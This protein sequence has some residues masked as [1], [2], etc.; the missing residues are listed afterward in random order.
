MGLAGAMEELRAQREQARTLMIG[1]V[2]ERQ[3]GPRRAI[4]VGAHVQRPPGRIGEERDSLRRAAGAEEVMGDALRRRV[5][6]GEER[7]GVGVG[8]PQSLLGQPG[9]EL[10]AH[11]RVSE[12]VAAACALEHATRLGL[13]ER[14]SDTIGACECDQRRLG[15]AII[16]HGESS[17]QPLAEQLEPFEPLPHDLAE[18]GRDR[19]LAGSV[20]RCR[21]LFGE[22]RVARRRACDGI[23]CF[24]RQRPAGRALRDCCQRAAVE[25]TE[26]QLHRGPAPEE[27]RSHER[28]RL[29]KWLIA[30]RGDYQ[31]PLAA[32]VAGEMMHERQRCFVSVVQVIDRQHHTALRGGLSQQ[33]SDGAEHQTTVHLLLRHPLRATHRRQQS[34]E[35]DL[36]AVAERAD[37]LRAA[38]GERVERFR[39]RRVGRSALRLVPCTAQCV[40][41]QLL[42]LGEH[43]L[44]QAR[45]ADPD[46]TGDQQRAPVRGR[47]TLQRDERRG[48][49]SLPS[50]DGGAKEPGRVNRRAP[51]EL[52][53]KRQ[54]LLR[55]LDA[56]P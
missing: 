45:L 19:D 2:L 1:G 44:E 39:E 9:R 28:R 21:Q 10:F 12:A 50:F 8:T 3:L 34:R 17:Q 31:Q 41:G 51:G 32:A 49:L 7:R 36:R 4:A 22:E 46:R 43:G 14:L 6:L 47:G 11:Q 23:E 16:D 30:H 40:E 5:L 33:L 48:E 26:R 55:R 54:R 56:Q 20:H 29:R 37:Q 24:R 53:L 52:A 25:R 35:R 38:V 13:A 27:P 15:E 18:P 42:R